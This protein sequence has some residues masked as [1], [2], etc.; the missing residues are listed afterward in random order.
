MVTLLGV[1]I[2][3]DL[4]VNQEGLMYKKL[5]KKLKKRM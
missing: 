2:L 4:G 1:A 3:E 5:R